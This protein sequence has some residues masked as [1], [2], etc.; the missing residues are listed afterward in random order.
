MKKIIEEFAVE[1][2]KAIQEGT[3]EGTSPNQNKNLCQYLTKEG[4]NITLGFEIYS[5]KIDELIRKTK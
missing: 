1:R 5:D 3:A 2:F 4:L